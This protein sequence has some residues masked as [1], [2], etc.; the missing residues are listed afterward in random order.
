MKKKTT[1]VN[2]SSGGGGGYAKIIVAGSGGI[3]SKMKLSKIGSAGGNS[4]RGSI[5]HISV[6]QPEEIVEALSERV[7]KKKYPIK[8]MVCSGSNTGCRA[9]LDGVCC[10]VHNP[11]D[12]PKNLRRVDDFATEDYVNQVAYGKPPLFQAFFMAVI[13]ISLIAYT[14]MK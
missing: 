13:I 7:S 5:T 14:L 3:S 12:V 1:K 8:V 2:T 4:D 11:I 10:E 6:P 9:E